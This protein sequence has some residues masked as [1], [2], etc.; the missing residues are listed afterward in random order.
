M[1]AIFVLHDIW[2]YF[3]NLSSKIDLYESKSM[4]ISKEVCPIV[5]NVWSSVKHRAVAG[6]ELS[7]LQQLSKS[8]LVKQAMVL[9]SSCFYS[10]VRFCKIFYVCRFLANQ[11][12]HYNLSSLPSVPMWV[13]N[14][15]E[16][17]HN[18]SV[19]STMST[20]A[21]SADPANRRYSMRTSEYGKI[22][23]LLLVN[24]LTTFG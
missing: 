7:R 20:H 8:F 18:L 3:K 14:I 2:S 23:P 24:R 6:G 10:S 15:V 12:S 22:L 4:Q 5:V 16:A 19:S 17:V 1:K 21:N 11:R 9:Q 13:Q